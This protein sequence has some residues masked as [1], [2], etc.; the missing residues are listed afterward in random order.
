MVNQFPYELK[1]F[2]EATADSI[3]LEMMMGPIFSSIPT[4]PKERTDFNAT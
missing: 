3:L 4:S 1:P 2:S